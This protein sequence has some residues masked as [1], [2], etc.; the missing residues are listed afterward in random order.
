MRRCRA[1]V[2]ATGMSDDERGR[3]GQ[4]AAMSDEDETFELAMRN[5][6]IKPSARGARPKKKGGVEG[7]GVTVS[8]DIDFD[9]LMR[10]GRGPASELRATP[11]AKRGAAADLPEASIPNRER[12]ATPRTIERS[13][14]APTPEEAREFLAAM[15]ELEPP[16]VSEREP[17]RPRP[18]AASD[19]DLGRRL[20]RGD[21][22]VAA[23]LD[24]HGSNRKEARPKLEAFIKEAVEER[25]ELVAIVTGRG[26]NSQRDPVLRPAV[27]G[28]L[29]EDLRADVREVHPAPPYLGGSGAWIAAIRVG[30]G[31]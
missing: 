8:E 22:E 9:A 24:L 10:E 25:W 16:A 29:R 7:A 19:S 11:P 26:L 13:R 15:A 28:W 21:V 1:G 23:V 4:T 3:L 30:K 6:G 2:N 5:L 14:H 17:A 27:E 20:K 18:P 12:A 31:R